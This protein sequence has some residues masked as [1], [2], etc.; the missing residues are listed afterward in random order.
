MY[1][2]IKSIIIAVIIGYSI[3]C[4]Y[5]FQSEKEIPMPTGLEFGLIIDH[6]ENEINL[7]LIEGKFFFNENIIKITINGNIKLSENYKETNSENNVI[8]GFSALE[9]TEYPTFT[10]LC[11]N[12]VNY[13][14][15]NNNKYNIYERKESPGYKYI[16]EIPLKDLKDSYTAFTGII[17]FKSPDIT[18][19]IYIKINPL[20]FEGNTNQNSFVEIF[21]LEVANDEYYFEDIPCG[22]IK[23]L[24]STSS[25]KKIF[26]KVTYKKNS[27][28]WFHIIKRK[29]KNWPIILAFYILLITLLLAFIQL[30]NNNENKKILNEIK[31]IDTCWI[32]YEKNRWDTI[33][34][35][36][37]NLIFLI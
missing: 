20:F 6:H 27:E 13:I 5:I 12:E 1:R 2:I 26:A 36:I 33:K 18:E 14:K 17:N 8:L 31:Q 15:F 28:Y 24:E 4:C 25:P 30:T 23:G 34:K 7:E 29:I 10:D 16:C 32:K 9:K 11:V 21:S 35:K 3:Y 22:A 37:K 19:D